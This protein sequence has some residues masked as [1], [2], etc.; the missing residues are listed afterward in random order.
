MMENWPEEKID[1]GEWSDLAA[2]EESPV[3]LSLVE[4]NKSLGLFSLA[5]SVERKVRRIDVDETVKLVSRARDIAEFPRRTTEDFR[6]GVAVLVDRSDNMQPFFGDQ[7]QL[8]QWLTRIV[9]PSRIHVSTFWDS[10]FLGCRN[11]N[12][13]FVSRFHLPPPKRPILLLSDLGLGF[14]FASAEADPFWAHQLFQ[15]AES[16]GNRVVLL[17]PYPESSRPE[18]VHGVCWLHWDRDLCHRDTAK[19]IRSRFRK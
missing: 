9:G 18:W 14:G 16:N 15:A 17:T 2:S 13:Q 1:S 19:K 4:R 3:T 6:N 5:L 11:L 10:P 7:D 8:V 12:G